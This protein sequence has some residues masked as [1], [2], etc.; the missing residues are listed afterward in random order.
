MAKKVKNTNSRTLIKLDDKI[1]EITVDEKG[2]IAKELS[3]ED[4]FDV[5]LLDEGVEKLIKN[6]IN[7]ITNEAYA[8]LQQGFKNKLK[9]NVLRLAGFENRWGNGYEVDHCNGRQSMMTEYISKKVQDYIKT[10]LDKLITPDEV[11]EMLKPVKE[12]LLKDMKEEFF[13]A[14]RGRLQEEMH[15]TAKNFVSDALKK[16]VTKYQK[17]AFEKAQAAFLGRT[18]ADFDEHEEDEDY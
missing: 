12:T 6:D 4:L 5:S 7:R 10:E 2:L 8:E 9:E 1:I 17:D 11:K 18:Y 14:V 13:D 3:E 15:E 16:T